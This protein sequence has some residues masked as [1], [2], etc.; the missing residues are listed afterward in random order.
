MTAEMFLNAIY[1]GNQIKEVLSSVEACG[2][3]SIYLNN[4]K[5]SKKEKETLKK[6][7]VKFRQEIS[8]LKKSLNDYKKERRANWKEFKIR[9]KEEISKLK[10]RPASA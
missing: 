4:I 3:H 5:M 1:Q 10:K 9:M 2:I 7:K 6:E 8:L